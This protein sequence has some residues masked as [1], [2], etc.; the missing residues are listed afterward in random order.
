VVRVVWREALEAEPPEPEVWLGY[1]ELC[2]FLGQDDEYLRA[3]RALLDR[4]G[5][6]TDSYVAERIGRACLLLPAP[7]D[8]LR[9]ATALIDR[10]VA[11]GR[12]K[13]DWAYPHFMFAKGLAEYRQNHMD[14]AIAVLKGKAAR[15][16]GPNPRMVLAM[17]QYRQGRKEEALHTLAAAI[18]AFDWGANQADNPGT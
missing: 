17:A 8:E 6:S 7:E 9:Q 13:P 1:A 16:P 10:A 4:F 5:T 3:R 15:V 2:L 12:S 11:A 14:S 18:V